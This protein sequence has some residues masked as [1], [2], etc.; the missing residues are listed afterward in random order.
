[1]LLKQLSEQSLFK[2]QQHSISLRISLVGEALPQN[3]QTTEARKL[4]ENVNILCKNKMDQ[5]NRNLSGKQLKGAR[6]QG[7]QDTWTG[8]KSKS[9][10]CIVLRK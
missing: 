4:N 5:Y 10:I 8:S 9:E 1:M 3:S 7:I 6:Y 2:E